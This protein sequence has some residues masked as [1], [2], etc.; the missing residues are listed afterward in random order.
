M[1]NQYKIDGNTLVVYNRKDNREILFDVEDIDLLQLKTYSYYVTAH[2]YC[3]NNILG[4][5][6]R[7]IMNAP[8]DLQVDHINGNRL[9]NRKNNL[10]LATSQMNN[11][12]N[13]VAKGYSFEK[14]RN[15]WSASIKLNRKK[16]HLGRYDTEAEA[17]QAYLKAKKIYH[18]TALIG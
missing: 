7:L 10:R 16:I 9:D 17:R 3:H 11:H 18:P 4:Y 13:T 15:K 6:H 5:A 14:T 12:N 1:R 2:N 8:K